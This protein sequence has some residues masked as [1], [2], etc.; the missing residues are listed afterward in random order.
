MI[1]LAQLLLAHFVVDFYLQ[2]KTWVLDKETK[3]LKS[4]TLYFH[5]VLYGVVTML[6][7]WDWKFFPW[8]ILLSVIHL[9][10]D[11]LK[12]TLQTKLTKRA[13]FFADQAAHLASIYVVYCVYLHQPILTLSSFSEQHW[14]LLTAV[15][16]LT[17]PC[18]FF[19]RMFIAKWSPDTEEEEQESLQD[20]GKYIG[21]LERLFV[22]VFVISAHW[23]AVG[24]LIAAKS[25][26]RFGDL[27]ESKDRK[28]T[29]YILI[30]TLLSFGIAMVVGMLLTNIA[31]I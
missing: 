8:A 13:Y 15:T 12:V 16:F 26:F 9:I 2:P 21:I 7:V 4:L 25:V 22:F 31:H 11:V 17:L 10:I 29:E 5:V 19:I 6:L 27:K 24:F 1:L 30:G 28:L 3:K 20:A 23:E 14:Y 18:S